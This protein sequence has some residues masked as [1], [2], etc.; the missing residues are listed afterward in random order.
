M[1]LVEGEFGL[2]HGDGCFAGMV[3]YDQHAL[4]SRSHL[5][6]MGA[7]VGI[8]MWLPVWE[9]LRVM[10]PW[11]WGWPAVKYLGGCLRSRIDK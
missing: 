7:L 11:Y 2:L 5:S 1:N 4:D 9:A 8:A 10:M 3:S 6:C